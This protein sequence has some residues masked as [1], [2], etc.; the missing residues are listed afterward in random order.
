MATTVLLDVMDDVVTGPCTRDR[1]WR[2]PVVAML[3]TFFAGLLVLI[4]C[5]IVWYKL[6]GEQKSRNKMKR[7]HVFSR[8][9]AKAQRV[10]SGNDIPSKILVGSTFVFVWFSISFVVNYLLIYLC[11][12][13]AGY[14]Y[15][16]CQLGCCHSLLGRCIN[17]C[18]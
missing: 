2:Q 1:Q 8:M 18:S 5:R 11:A 10:L 9:R 12:S 7:Y 3:I 15:V 14:F 13:I 16:P 6:Y 17:V 4:P